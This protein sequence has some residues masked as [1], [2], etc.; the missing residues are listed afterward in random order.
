[1][2]SHWNMPGGV[3][4]QSGGERW[5]HSGCTLEIEPAGP[6]DGLD[7]GLRRDRVSGF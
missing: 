5:A 6:G 1:M 3:G 7:Q 2:G 4:L